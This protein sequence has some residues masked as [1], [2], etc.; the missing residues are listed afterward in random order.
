[1]ETAIFKEAEEIERQSKSAEECFRRKL[2]LQDELDALRREFSRPWLLMPP[3]ERARRVAER[4]H[5]PSP[6]PL[7]LASELDPLRQSLLRRSSGAK[8][9]V[10]FVIDWSVTNKRLIRSFARKI[11][12]MRRTPGTKANLTPVKQVRGRKTTVKEQ[13]VRLVIWRCRKARYPT[14]SILTL[15]EPFRQRFGLPHKDTLRK[16]L[17]SLA[18]QAE[19][20]LFS[21]GL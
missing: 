10:D 9:R 12:S 21:P 18:D 17:A 7:R 14:D 20:M 13:L 3:E 8:E 1:M 15:L 5:L 2:D 6:E 11:K 16:K 19:R 4:K